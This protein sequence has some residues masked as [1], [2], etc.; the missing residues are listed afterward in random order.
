MTG[1]FLLSSYNLKASLR[2]RVR[3]SDHIAELFGQVHPYDIAD[4]C[5]SDCAVF[6][7]FCRGLEDV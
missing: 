2:S 6:I 7:G 5:S 4:D 1:H 3:L